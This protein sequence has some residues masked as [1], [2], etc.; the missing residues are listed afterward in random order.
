MCLLIISESRCPARISER[1]E[2]IWA[3]TKQRICRQKKTTAQFDNAVREILYLNGGDFGPVTEENVNTYANATANSTAKA[4]EGAEVEGK[5][6]EQDED[7]MAGGEKKEEVKTAGAIEEKMK[8][9]TVEEMGGMRG[10]LQG[11]IL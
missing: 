5:E 3:E 6:D 11:K 10:L 1:F 7:G 8:E 4:V 9:M 2:W